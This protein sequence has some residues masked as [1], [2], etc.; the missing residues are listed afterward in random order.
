MNS[1][2]YNRSNYFSPINIEGNLELDLSEGSFNLFE[3][4]KKIRY[5]QITKYE[6][7]RPDIISNNIYGTTDHWWI[8]LKYNNIVDIFSE[9]VEGFILKIPAVSDIQKFNK[10]IKLKT[11]R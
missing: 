6:S 7:N 1:K 8:I 4:T 9:L 3:T 5:Y 11:T 10:K 2:K